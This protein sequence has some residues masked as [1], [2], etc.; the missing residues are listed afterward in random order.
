MADK[1]NKEIKRFSASVPGFLLR[2]CLI[3]GASVGLVLA[4]DSGSGSQANKDNSL[5]NGSF[6]DPVFSDDKKYLTTSQDDVPYWNTTATN[7]KIELFHGNTGTYIDNVTLTPTNGKN[8][9]ELNADEEST[10]Y[11]IVKTSPASVYEWGLDHGARNGTDTMA[12]V[13]GPG[14]SV[15]PSKPSS[16]GRDQLMQMVDW[17]IEQG[18][19]SVKTAPGIDEQHLTVYS[20]KFAAGGTFEDNAGNNAFSLTPSTIYTEEWHI[21]IMASS[22][23]TTGNNPWSKYGANAEGSAASTDPSGNTGVDLSK[24]YLYTVPADQSKTLFGFVSVGT[25]GKNKTFGNFLDN[26]KFRIYYPLSGSTTAHGSAVIGGS[27]GTTGGTGATEGYEVTVD[28]KLT[29][30]INDGEALK[31]QAVVKQE[32]ADGGCEFVG[33]YY[34]KQ[35]DDG[36][37][38]T[39]FLRLA[40]ND[41][42]DNGSLTNEQK[43]GKWVR[44]TNAE[45]DTVYTYYLEGLSSATDLHFIFIK[46]PTVTYDPNGGKTYE[47]DRTYNKGEAGNV[48]SF[49]PVNDPNASLGTQIT[50]IPPCVSHAAEGDEGWKFMGWQLTGDVVDNIP[51]DVEQVNAGQ[52]GDLL[53]P[54]EHTIA[55]DYLDAGIGNAKAAQYFKIYNGKVTLTKTVNQNDQKEPTGVIWADNREEKIYANVHKGLTM[56]AQW[57]WQQAFIPQVNSNSTYIN[58]ANG[59]T[60]E[61][62]SVTDTNDANYNAAYNDAGGKSYHAAM[63]E[64]VTAKATAKDGF[65]FEGWYDA[66]GNLLTPNATYSYTETRESV[67]TYYARFSGSV[68]QTYT[69]Q[70]KVGDTWT[71]TADDS[72][73]TLGRYT[74]V[75][76]VGVP[77]S[78]TATAGTGYKFVGWYDTDG[79]KVAESML[80]NSGATISY[81]TTGDATYYARFEKAYTIKFA[82]QTKQADGSFKTDTVGG[83]VSVASVTDVKN[84]AA[85][86]KATANTGYKFLGWYDT[87]GKQLSTNATYSTTIPSAVNGVTYYARFEIN[88]QVTIK[89]PFLSFVAESADTNIPS[90]FDGRNT[91]TGKGTADYGLANQFGNTIATGFTYS[92]NSMTN[93]S[94]IQ[95]T[96]TV[97]AAAY[98]KVGGTGS[99]SG[100]G[101]SILTDSG[102]VAYNK[103][104]IQQISGETTLTYYWDASGLEANKTYGFVIDNLYAPGATAAITVNGTTDTKVTGENGVVNTVSGSYRDKSHY[105]K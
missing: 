42:E 9:A 16:N 39:E 85:S 58:S 18:K 64:T 66:K 32:D 103:G 20:K 59:G 86:S 94:T 99:F 88:Y 44:S 92:I 11:Q 67:N 10:L 73:G 46:S 72:I 14:Q 19:T 34:T 101:T 40:G 49:R 6:E 15:A 89:G 7:T 27:D 87:D 62:T 57:R 29:T 8:A 28:N 77:I 71:D 2:I 35:G 5:N 96:V 38:K 54:A 24:Y 56:V 63:D 3:V 17:L 50:Y 82:A 97:P 70:V 37:P 55:C 41:I 78:S 26:I 12:L 48:Y 22:C 65:T 1:E 33:V 95:I 45:G 21:W 80:A 100:N 36:K 53:F 4:A 93:V 31:I 81:T 60:V 91:G 51:G 76:A 84:A 102:G 61:I 23:A 105:P 74:Y 30:Y 79:N 25:T 98:V 75:D 43:K 52:L 90:A 69:R 68:T 104:S 47:V 13:I 83:K